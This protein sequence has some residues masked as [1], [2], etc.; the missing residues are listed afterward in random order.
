MPNHR[1]VRWL[2]GPNGPGSVS[3][4]RRT[5]SGTSDAVSSSTSRLDLG[6]GPLRSPATYW[7]AGSRS[8]SAQPGGVRLDLATQEDG[9]AAGADELG[10]CGPPTRV[11]VLHAAERRDVVTVA[12]GPS[13]TGRLGEVGVRAAEGVPRHV[14]EHMG[15]AVSGHRSAPDPHGQAGDAALELLEL[16]DVDLGDRVAPLTV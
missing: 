13:V 12:A 16:G 10:Q 11:E 14:V 2:F 9:H 4:A 5:M 15:P 8:S 3:A 1:P 6:G 7:V